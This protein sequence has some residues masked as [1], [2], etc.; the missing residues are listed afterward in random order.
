LWCCNFSNEVS[1]RS[2]KSNILELGYC[3]SPL[4]AERRFDPLLDC[5]RA[6]VAEVSPLASPFSLSLVDGTSVSVSLR[7]HSAVLDFPARDAVLCSSGFN[8]YNGCV[9]CSLRFVREGNT[10]RPPAPPAEPLDT[11]QLR[12]WAP[13]RD[14]AAIRATFAAGIVP[15]GFKAA[16]PLLKLPHFA[17]VGQGAMLDALHLLDEGVYVGEEMVCCSFRLLAAFPSLRNCR[18][19][20]K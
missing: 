19:G 2:Q 4:A 17:L 1:H 14:D 15:D 3:F 7:V 5:C 9:H 10:Q 6:V 20:I 11:A 13:L 12:A 8:S 18:T 16:S